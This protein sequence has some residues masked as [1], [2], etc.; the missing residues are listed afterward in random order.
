MTR[1]WRRA[2]I[3]RMSVSPEPRFQTV[4]I[5]KGRHDS[6]ARGACVMELSSMLA[7][8][9]FDDHP[10]SVCPVIAGFLRS[11]ND[12]LPDGQ[13][14]E[15]YSYAALVVGTAGPRA[16]R[17]ERARR[18]LELDLHGRRRRSFRVRL[19][20]WDLILLPAVE[21]VLR[22]DPE[23]RRTVVAALI[24]ELCAMGRPPDAFAVEAGA[25]RDSGAATPSAC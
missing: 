17:R 23:R 6:P 18:I 10:R 21:A 20:S 13:H 16:I 1:P 14:D 4:T 19:Q 12:L 24:D 7:G 11:Y 22:L 8:E 15:L 3:D 5:R 9:R 25:A 2:T